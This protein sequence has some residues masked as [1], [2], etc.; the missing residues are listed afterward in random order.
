MKKNKKPSQR[1][2]NPQ[3]AVQDALVSVLK[4]MR[5]LLFLLSKESRTQADQTEIVRLS[6]TMT[7]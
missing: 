4:S 2:N 3:P 7:E 1:K 5:R 6:A